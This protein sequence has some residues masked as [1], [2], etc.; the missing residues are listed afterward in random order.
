MVTIVTTLKEAACEVDFDLSA[1]A[2]Y[3]IPERMERTVYVSPLAANITPEMVKVTNF[4]QGLCIGII[5]NIKFSPFRKYSTQRNVVLLS[6]SRLKSIGRR[7]LPLLKPTIY[8]LVEFAHKD[9]VEVLLIVIL[10]KKLTK[11]D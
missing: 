6:R 9:S 2:E 10:I 3:R 11:F 7:R 8:A 5:E 4:C 1:R